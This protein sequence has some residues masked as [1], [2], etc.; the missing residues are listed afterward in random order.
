MMGSTQEHSH[1]TL[2]GASRAPVAVGSAQCG[3]G[4]DSLGLNKNRPASG[5]G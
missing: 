2:L 1:S 3:L 5:R 4:K